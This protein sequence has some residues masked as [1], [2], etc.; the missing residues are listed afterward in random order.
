MLFVMRLRRETPAA[1]EFSFDLTLCAGPVNEITRWWRLRHA[2]F[3]TDKIQCLFVLRRVLSP[4]G[5]V[6]LG[7]LL[8]YIPYRLNEVF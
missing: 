6:F 1:I 3:P 7:S 4:R 2:T 5:T 8:D